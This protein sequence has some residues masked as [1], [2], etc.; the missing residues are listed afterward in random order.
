VI[1]IP[2]I[3]EA[4]VATYR[5]KISIIMTLSLTRH[6]FYHLLC[7]MMLGGKIF[8]MTNFSRKLS[9]VMPIAVEGN[10]S[11]KPLSIPKNWM[12]LFGVFTN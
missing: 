3:Y 12:D 10:Y 2:N 5:N 9:Y 7:M 6:I 11:V 1:T 8:V 4:M